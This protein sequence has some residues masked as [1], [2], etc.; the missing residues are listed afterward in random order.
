M[1]DIEI[2]VWLLYKL[3][4][5][6]CWGKGHISADNL[7]KG[8]DSIHKKRILKIADGMVGEGLLI[9]FPH[10]REMHYHLNRKFIKEI[11]RLLEESGPLFQI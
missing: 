4:R 11:L 3:K 1:E 10:G 2:R 8:Q 6:G 9:R 5:K 7:V